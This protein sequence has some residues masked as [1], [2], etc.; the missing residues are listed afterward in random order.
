MP[1]PVCKKEYLAE[2]VDDSGGVFEA[3]RRDHPVV[4]VTD[5]HIESAKR[6]FAQI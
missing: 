2:F 5:I 6:L 1:D 3:V 4:M